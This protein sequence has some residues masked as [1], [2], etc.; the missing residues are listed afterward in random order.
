MP[1]FPPPASAARLLR[2]FPRLRPSLLRQQQPHP[3]ALSI[4]PATL[5]FKQFA[6]SYS[7]SS[8]GDEKETI[9]RLLYNIGSRREV[10]WYLNHFSSVESQKFAV[11]KVGGAIISENLDSLASSLTFLNKV[12]LYPIVVHGAGPQL[13]KLLEDASIEPNYIDGIR[14]TDAQTLTIARKVFQEENLKLVEALESLGTR[15]RPLNGGVF[16]A[17]YLDQSKYGYVGKIQKVNKQTIESA[18]TAGCLPVL[19]SLADT[20]DGQILN[21]NADVAASELAKVL[22]PLKIVY[23]SEKGGLFHGVTGKKLD[24]INL[25]EEYDALMKEPWVKYGTKLKIKEIHDLLMHL[26]RTSSVS[27]ISP[28]FLSKELFTHSGAGT[29]IRRG[30]RL[31]SHSSVSKLDIDRFR[32]LLSHDPE[33]QM[34]YTSP[35]EYLSKL[36]QTPKYEIFGDEAYE[37]VAVVVPS[38]ASSADSKQQVPVL[39]KFLFTKPAILNNV[40]D[41]LW[42]MLQKHYPSLVWT[43]PQN[44][45]NK[46]WF[47]ERSEGAVNVGDKIAMWY[48]VE[49]VEQIVKMINEAKK[50]E[51]GLSLSSYDSTVASTGQQ[52]RQYSTISAASRRSLMNS[53]IGSQSIRSYATT[54]TTTPPKTVGIIGARGYVGQE[55][56]KI[57]NTHPF[58]NLTHVSTRSKNLINT[59]VPDFTPRFSASSSELLYS[60][61]NPTPSE[62]SKCD[63]WILALPNNASTPYV[64]ALNQ[65]P[66]SERPV[67]VDLSADYRFDDIHQ[68]AYGLPEHYRDQIIGQKMISNPGCYATGAQFGLWALKKEGLIDSG[69]RASVFGVSGYSGAG[70]TPSPK[71]DPENLKD[72]LIPYSLINHIHEREVTR[73]CHPV[74]FSPHVAPFFRGITL[75]IHTP[76]L[77]SISSSSLHQLYASTYEGEP[78]VNVKEGI[79]ELR[80]IRNKNGVEIGGIVA[81]EQGKRVSLVVTI[82]NLLKGAAGQCIQNVNLSVAG[83]DGEFAGLV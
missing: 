34:G 79:P 68:W 66:S 17:S 18:I 21:V 56:I 54:S 64:S 23:I 70:T 26:P 19:T 53:P 63:I 65:I 55:L 67:V 25:D 81:D 73:H 40:T 11:I 60:T 2:S 5:A 12:G 27:I 69:N 13:N 16:T 76:L 61:V 6:R 44:E 80:D 77:K 46:S 20:P 42:S 15:A 33:I 83:K 57:L 48:G 58:L 35:A 45:P 75:T 7:G 8:S 59:P 29:L 30:H 52:K 47:F 74:H 43:I 41:N 51:L 71:N 31:F 10:E 49:D 39:D 24:V 4:R 3:L 62:L 1:T 78:L 9:T 82:D 38:D 50:G 22:E 72:N 37:V 36:S 14:V 28:E 32:N